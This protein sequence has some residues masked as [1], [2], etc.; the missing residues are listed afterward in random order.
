MQ[1]ESTKLSKELFYVIA[2][3]LNSC[4]SQDHIEVNAGIL[5]YQSGTDVAHVLVV[6]TCLLFQ[7]ENLVPNCRK[8]SK[9][10]GVLRARHHCAFCSV[11]L[12]SAC[13]NKDDVILFT[14]NGSAASVVCIAVVKVI[15]VRCCS[16]FWLQ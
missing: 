1:K 3:R 15:G 5:G 14:A 2:K 8:C 4:Q 9:P 12:C 13:V 11:A 16:T 6:K 10:F 7:L